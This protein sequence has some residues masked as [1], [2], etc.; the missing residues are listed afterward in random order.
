MFPVTEG[1][2]KNFSKLL[3]KLEEKTDILIT[4]HLKYD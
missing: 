4:Y 1:T 2:A 3:H